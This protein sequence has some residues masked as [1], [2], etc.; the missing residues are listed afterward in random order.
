MKMK[1]SKKI[2]SA[3]LALLMAATTLIVP[4]YAMADEEKNGKYVKEVFIAYGYTVDE[5]KNWLTSNGWE[6]VGEDLNAGNTSEN[7]GFKNAVAVMGIKRTNNANDAIT[8]MATMNMK[9]GYSFDDY[10]S[11]LNEKKADIDEFIKTFIPVLEEYR[12]NYNG[13]GSEGGQKRAQFAHDLLNKFYDGGQNEDYAGNDTGMPLGDLFLNKTTTELEKEYSELTAE[14]KKTTADLRQIIMES[15]GPAV[16]LIEEAL[17]FATDTRDSSWLDLLKTLTGDSL[18]KNVQKYV[19][20]AKG[21]K[22]TTSQAKSYLNTAY[23]DSAKKLQSEWGTIHDNVL[24]FEKYCADNDLWRK[25]DETDEQY[26][27]RAIAYFDNLKETN[28]DRYNEEFALYTDIG[29]YY[30]V[31]T[32]VTYSGAWGKT[33]YEF[34]ADPNGKEPGNNVDNF[35]PL[36][37]VLSPGQRAGIKFLSLSTLLKLGSTSEEVMAAQFPKINEL[38]KDETKDAISVYSGINR[39]IFRNGVALTSKARMQKDMG[40]DPYDAWLDNGGYG[41]IITYTMMGAGLVMIVAGAVMEVRAAAAYKVALEAQHIAEASKAEWSA[42]LAILDDKV[43]YSISELEQKMEALRNADMEWERLEAAFDVTEYQKAFDN[44][45]L[46]KQNFDKSMQAYNDFYEEMPQVT[47]A[48]MSTAGRWM[49]GIGGAIMLLT[50]IAKIVEI[51]AFY[52]REFTVIPT[53]IVDEADIV[54]YTTDENG[55]QVKEITFDQFAYYEVVKCNRQE[56]GLH[57]NA[58]DGVDEYDDWGCGDAADLN[59][60]V[61]KQWLA[62][63]VNRSSAKGNPI[64]A[65]SITVQYGSSGTPKGCTGN[66]HMFTFTNPVDVGDA[67]YCFRNDKNGTY[68]FWDSDK[69]AYSTSTETAGAIN[70]GYLALAAVGG[71][72]LGIVVTTFF[73]LPKRKKENGA[74]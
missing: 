70:Y 27:E 54:N 12:A 47:E 26:N 53:M 35:L 15:T 50:A 49:M 2:L 33:L 65:D 51:T 3:F 52:D 66:L 34:F 46:A 67:A 61:G 23:Q 44:A 64:L 31:L 69:E 19:D 59:A 72:A 6:P 57:K 24:W 40:E 45:K 17:S 21:K 74:E 13:E 55:K 9:G 73:I 71:L 25:E 32:D 11:L 48:R 10:Q 62:L 28:E 58:Q 43:G 16:S 5:A 68:L 37:A 20:A 7:V 8:D 42:K 14:E 41:D 29:N 22:L 56:I 1:L 63:Y 38:F 4:F 30:T 39:G 18:K 60:D 36:A